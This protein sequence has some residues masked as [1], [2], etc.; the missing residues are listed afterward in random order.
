MSISRETL[1][2]RS[3]SSS[4]VVVLGAGRG[5]ASVIVGWEGGNDAEPPCGHPRHV[6]SCDECGKFERSVF[7]EP[8]D[9]SGPDPRPIVRRVALPL[10]SERKGLVKIL[11]RSTDV[12]TD[13]RAR[14]YS[15]EAA[16]PSAWSC[17]G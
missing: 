10:V 9:P 17:V 11:L 3:Q 8:D 13:T 14:E 4:A 12:Q 7:E 16:V 15:V 6:E 5:L 1:R 2:R